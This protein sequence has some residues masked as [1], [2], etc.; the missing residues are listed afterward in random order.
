[1]DLRGAFGLGWIIWGWVPMGIVIGLL[2]CVWRIIYIRSLVS[3]RKAVGDDPALN[4]ATAVGIA[5]TLGLFI[6]F[7]V[8]IEIGVQM[9]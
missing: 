2:E 4:W 8:L 1:M 3:Y 9:H 5:V 7:M 6:A